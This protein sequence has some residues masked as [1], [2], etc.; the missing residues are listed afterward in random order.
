MRLV[1]QAHRGF[2]VVI[3]AALALSVLATPAPARAAPSA[4]RACAPSESAGLEDVWVGRAVRM[5]AYTAEGHPNGDLYLR[6]KVTLLPS[7]IAMKELSFMLWADEKFQAAHYNPD[8]TIQAAGPFT[9]TDAQQQPAMGTWTC[10]F[11]LD[12]AE[13]EATVVTFENYAW[14][15]TGQLEDLFTLGVSRQTEVFRQLAGYPNILKT[16]VIVDQGTPYVQSILNTFSNLQNPVLDPSVGGIGAFR[17]RAVVTYDRAS[18]IHAVEDLGAI[19]LIPERASLCDP[20][21]GPGA[22]LTGPACPFGNATPTPTSTPTPT[23]TATP[24]PFI[25]TC[26]SPNVAIPDNNPTGISDTLILP[27]GGAIADLNVVIT[28]SHTWVGDLVFTLTHVDTGTAVRFIDRPGYPGTGFGCN[29]DDLSNNGVDDEGALSAETGCVSSGDLSPIA[30]YPPGA[31]LIPNNPLSAFD[32]ETLAGAWRM[33]VSDNAQGDTGGLNAWCMAAIQVIPPTD[34]P[35]PTSTATA[36]PTNTPMPA[37]TTTH[38]PSPT[39]TPTATATPIGFVNVCSSPNLAIPDNSTA[40]ISDTLTIPAGGTISDLNV[41]ISVTHTWVGDLNIGLTH[42]ASG[43]SAT[44]LDRPNGNAGQCSGDNLANSFDD[45]GGLAAASQ[46]A[47][48]D[49]PNAAYPAGASLIPGQP[50]SI[51]DGQSL[52]GVWRITVSDNAGSDIGALNTWCVAAVARRYAFLPI[53]V[54]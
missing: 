53:T 23:P 48:D 54:R 22:T 51:F 47:S 20:Y 7:G 1:K 30:A 42:L 9:V 33:T 13:P 39:A 26:S 21:A 50:L 18:Q 35:T 41:F 45:E 34:T 3:G 43:T 27:A 16:K 10:D 15:N 28:A 5:Q 12:T 8:G 31:A 14:S 36:T 46:C 32:G 40:G 29:G 4:S 44:L 24:S 37:A 11:N 19:E 6:H 49:G 38:T 2:A 52:A 25:N 17:R